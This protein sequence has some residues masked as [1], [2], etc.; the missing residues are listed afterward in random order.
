MEMG[1]SSD[2]D[3]NFLRRP[4]LRPSN[5]VLN[6]DEDEDYYADGMV[7]KNFES[8]STPK[9]S[10]DCSMVRS[11]LCSTPLPTMECDDVSYLK[12]YEVDSNMNKSSL[13]STPMVSS[14]HSCSLPIPTLN[15]MLFSA[16][17]RHCRSVESLR[18]YR[19]GSEELPLEYM[20]PFTPDG[21]LLLNKANAQKQLK[22]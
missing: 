5:R 14:N 12:L 6:F 9:N 20:N 22:R 13:T 8:P 17:T 3:Y 19:V 15:R 1:D 16:D 21:K 4:K 18:L 2:P 7:L 10:S 11:D